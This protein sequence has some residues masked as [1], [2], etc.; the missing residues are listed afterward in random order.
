GLTE[1]FNVHMNHSYHGAFAQDQWKITPRLTFNYGLRWDFE[2]GLTKQV[3][4]DFRNFA[5][6]L[7]IAYSPDSRT[8]IRAG[9]GIFFDRYNLSFFLVTPPRG[10]PGEVIDLF[11]G[12]ETFLRGPRRGA[13]SAGYTLNQDPTVITPPGF[14]VAN[15][16]ADARTLLLT[17]QL[18][19]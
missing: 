18:P 2:G 4:H 19:P 11:T 16:A 12:K 14:F 5:P 17:G 15:A 1:A 6:R 9:G 3:N 13:S 8:V 10:P 7:G